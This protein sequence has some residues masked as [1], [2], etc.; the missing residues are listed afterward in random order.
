[1]HL[2]GL[3]LLGGRSGSALVRATAV[4]SAA[5]ARARAEGYRQRGGEWTLG[6]A[7]GFRSAASAMAP[8]KVRLLADPTGAF[9][10]ET[11]LLLDDSLVSLFGNRRLKRF[12]MV[13]E[14]G[15]VRSLNVEPDGTGLTCSLAPNIISQL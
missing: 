10:K 8:I 11:D 7:S 5:S 2:A 14:D 12:S 6:G 9:G 15:I 4:G 1:M 3:H 13:V